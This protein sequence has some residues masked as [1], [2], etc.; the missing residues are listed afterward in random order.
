MKN[1]IQLKTESKKKI[2]LEALKKTMNNVSL[3]TQ[4]A[5]VDRTTFYFWCNEDPKFLQKVN[6]LREFEGDFAESQLMKLVSEKHFPSIKMVLESARH[7]KRG[8]TNESTINV[9]QEPKIDFSKY[10]KEEFEQNV[11]NLFDGYFN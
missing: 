8:Y 9:K 7:K 2:L 3:A 4:K 1:K 11:I 6:D 5:G 10:T